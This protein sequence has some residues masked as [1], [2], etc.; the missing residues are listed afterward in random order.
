MTDIVVNAVL[1]HGLAPYISGETS[2]GI[3]TKSPPPPP[4]PPRQNGCHFPDGSYKCIF[5]NENFCISIRISLRFVS[6]ALIDNKSACVR[7]MARHRTGDKPLSEPML[8]QF[9]NAYMQ[10]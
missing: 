5:M 8:T 1:V 10:H 2:A 7:V 9:T 3:L 6:R 4:P